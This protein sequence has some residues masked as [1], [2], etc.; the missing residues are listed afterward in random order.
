[1]DLSILWAEKFPIPPHAIMALLALVIGGVQMVAPKGTVPHK[2][3]GWV[4]VLL[5][6]GVAFSALFI[7][8]MRVIGPFSPIHLLI[9]VVF[10]SL[11]VAIRAA[12][13]GN[14]RRH[15]ITMRYLYF[16]ALV[17]TGAFTLLPG[18]AMHQVIFGS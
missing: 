8:Q 1:M 6:A 11:W 7:H 15:R 12:R 13:A 4:W 14:I 3:L 18:R 5:M 2:A 9:P 10:I 17:V 16:L